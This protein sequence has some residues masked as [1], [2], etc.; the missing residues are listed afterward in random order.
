MQQKSGFYMTTNND[1]LSDWTEKLQG[2]SQSQTCPQKRSWSLFGGLLRI[3]YTIAF[4]ILMKLLHLSMLCKLLRYTKNFNAC[5]WHWSTEGPNSSPWQ[6]PITCHASKVEWIRTMKFCLIHHIHL[7]SLLQ[8]SDYQLLLASWQLLQGKCLHNQQDAENSF[9]EFSEFES[10][11][12]Y[13]TGT[14]IFLVGRSV[15]IVMVPI[16]INKDVFK[17]GYNDLKYMVQNHNHFCPNSA[18]SD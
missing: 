13:T 7:T 16:L 6:L 1:Q 4:W 11:D 15:L 8:A 17:P 12:F 2:T 10:T 18:N 14:E 5:S 9:Q 3:W